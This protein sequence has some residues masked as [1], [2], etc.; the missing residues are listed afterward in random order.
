M[1]AV[2]RITS[3]KNYKK[4]GGLAINITTSDKKANKIL[5]E[6][7]IDTTNLNPGSLY[8]VMYDISHTLA[9]YGINTIFVVGE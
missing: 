9:E 7:R 5:E 4:D 3:K 8:V 1:S 6:D 2:F